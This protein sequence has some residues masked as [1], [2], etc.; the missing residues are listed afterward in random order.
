MKQK[1]HKTSP[2]LHITVHTPSTTKRN[3][4]AFIS[5][6][7]GPAICAGLTI[8]IVVDGGGTFIGGIWFVIGGGWFTKL[9]GGACS[10]GNI[11]GGQFTL[12]VATPIPGGGKIGWAINDGIALLTVTGLEG[13][14]PTGR[15]TEIEETDAK[16]FW[17]WRFGGGTPVVMFWIWLFWR[18]WGGGTVCT[19]IFWAILC[20]VRFW[21]N[22]GGV[23]V[24][25][26][27]IVTG[28]MLG[29][30]R[31]G[32]F[33]GGTLTFVSGKF[34]GGI[35]LFGGGIFFIKSGSEIDLSSLGVGIA[36]KSSGL[37]FGISLSWIEVGVGIFWTWI[38]AGWGIFS[39]FR[40]SGWGI[41]WTW[42]GFGGGIDANSTAGTQGGGTGIAAAVETVTDCE[43][44]I[45]GGGRVTVVRTPDAGIVTLTV[46]VDTRTLPCEFGNKTWF[47]TIWGGGTLR[48]KGGAAITDALLCWVT[49][50]KTT[51][52]GGSMF[53][54][55][56]W[57]V[58]F[59]G[60][61]DIWELSK[62]TGLLNDVLI[63]IFGSKVLDFSAN[64][65]IR[66]FKLRSFGDRERRFW[67][68]LLFLLVAERCSLKFWLLFFFN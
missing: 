4:P 65:D 39:A 33:G 20:T 11:G 50:G 15:A 29:G 53:F 34:G 28:I 31:T 9:G 59:W 19:R 36:N 45:E 35:D 13:T 1:S 10:C 66:D 56:G 21:G 6:Y 46:G 8:A 23:M 47:C 60:L 48:S 62:E 25:G 40:G 5:R 63:V 7:C 44:I 17:F 52:G 54:N 16:L 42:M 12:T 2:P 26:G 43:E 22:V 49:V 27:G 64:R 14:T 58:T 30:G 32:V 38:G 37:G 68:H 67:D 24:C 51:P 61:I 18:S 57:P 3:L 41:F 55:R